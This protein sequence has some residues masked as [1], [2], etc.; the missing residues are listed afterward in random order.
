M[1]LFPTFFCPK[2]WESMSGDDTCRFCTHCQKKVHNLDALSAEARAALLAS[3]AATL[4]GR[5]RAAIRRPAPGRERAY[6]RHLA[7]YGAGVAAAGAATFVLWEARHYELGP[8]EYL[9][10]RIN[11][12]LPEM[13]ATYFRQ[14]DVM[15]LGMICPTDEDAALDR[16][17][18]AAT[19]E[20]VAAARAPRFTLTREQVQALLPPTAPEFQALGDIPPPPPTVPA[21]PVVPSAVR[22]EH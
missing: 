8:I 7:K 3:P 1:P 16:P 5:Y 22:A 14:D 19:W 6:R 2:A 18:A 13:P 21:G 20:D 11:G 10:G 9:V 17:P 4:C 12:D 15:I